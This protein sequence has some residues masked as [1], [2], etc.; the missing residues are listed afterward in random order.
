MMKQS[1]SGMWQMRRAD[2][3]DWHQAVIPGSVYGTLLADGSM[4]DPYYRENEA[5][6][7]ELMYHDWLF[8]RSFTVDEA[9]LVQPRVLLNCQGLDTLAHV[10]ING[11]DVG[12]A[13]NMHITWCWNVKQFLQ[14]GENHITVAF[15]SPLNYVLA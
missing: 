13:D 10:S 2:Q 1:L 12:D 6:Y 15:D 8:S 14:V 5:Q 11:H 7:F 4:P 3:Q 9:L